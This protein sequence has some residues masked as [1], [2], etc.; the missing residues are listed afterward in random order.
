MKREKGQKYGKKRYMESSE[1]A[2]IHVIKILDEEEKENGKK[3]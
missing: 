3:N 2:N 1:L